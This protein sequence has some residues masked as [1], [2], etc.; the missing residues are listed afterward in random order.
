[1]EVEDEM[2][3]Q[4]T[5][6][7]VNLMNNNKYKKKFGNKNSKPGTSVSTS[8]TVM[9]TGLD[10]MKYKPAGGMKCFFCKKPGHFKKDCEGFKAW[11]KKKGIVKDFNP[12]K[13]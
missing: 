3:K 2:K 7:A 12:K 13:E 1:M 6:M 5:D 9:K 11:L 8:K 10:K 4:G